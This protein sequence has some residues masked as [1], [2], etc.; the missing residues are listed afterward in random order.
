MVVVPLLFTAL[1]FV[2][3]AFTGARLF[4]DENAGLE[5]GA[6]VFIAGIAGAV[7]GLILSILLLRSVGSRS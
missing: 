2:A 3:G 5:G 1:G 6:T 7:I 4:V